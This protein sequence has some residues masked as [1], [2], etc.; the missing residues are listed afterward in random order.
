MCR[1]YSGFVF[2]SF[3]LVIEL[4]FFPL[5]FPFKV[6]KRV[7]IPQ[8][9]CFGYFHLSLIKLFFFFY[10]SLNGLQ[11]G[12][13]FSIIRLKKTRYCKVNYKKKKKKTLRDISIIT[14]IFPIS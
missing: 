1:K 14:F 8:R 12:F 7:R 2:K 13:R 6:K 9:G 5:L 10:H 4:D 11:N 3:N